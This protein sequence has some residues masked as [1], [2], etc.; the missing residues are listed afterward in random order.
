[1]ALTIGPRLRR[2]FA[3]VLPAIVATLSD[4]GTPEMTPVWY[5]FADGQILLNGDKTRIW[6]D[7]MEKT[8][9]ATFLVVDPTNFWRW[10]QVYGKVVE[11]ADDPGG[12]HI[13]HLAHRY[14]GTDYSGD[15][16]TRRTVRI[17]ITSV[18]GADGSREIKWDV[19]V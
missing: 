12:E 3:E 10:V 1:M 15:R 13:N 19:G 18:K 11:V 5:E 2:F 6:L 16:S 17:E 9:R 14:R 8:G 7:R 4:R